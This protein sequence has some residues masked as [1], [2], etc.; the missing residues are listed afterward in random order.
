MTIMSASFWVLTTVF[1][2]DIHRRRSYVDLRLR[3]MLFKWQSSVL[4][5]N[6]TPMFRRGVLSPHSWKFNL[7]QVDAALTGRRKGSEYTWML[8][9]FKVC[10]QSNLRKGNKK[11]FPP[12][13]NSVTLIMEATCSSETSEE[14]CYPTRCKTQTTTIWGFN[15]S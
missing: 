9:G 6:I 4:L 13:P 2:L 3:H 14:T 12:E 10:G 5:N 15:F 7:V 1:F 11:V 8:Q